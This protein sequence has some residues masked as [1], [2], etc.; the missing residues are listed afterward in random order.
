[1]KLKQILFASPLFPLYGRIVRV[2]KPKSL[3][4]LALNTPQPLSTKYGLDRGTPVNRYWIRKA[5]AT[6][7]SDITGT[8]LE[9]GDRRY[10]T[11]FGKQSVK[12]SDILD[13]VPTNSTATIIGDLRN[14]KEQIKNNTYDC[15]ILTHVLGM[16]D[17]YPA[18]IRE[19]HRIL[20]PGGVMLVTVSSFSPVLEEAASYWRFTVAGAKY[21]FSQVFSK[22]TVQSYGNVYSGQAFWVGMAQEELSVSELDYDDPR[23]PCVIAIR[24]VKE[25]KV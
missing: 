3:F 24:A 8:V 13:I 6:W 20:K 2:V 17:D 1:M 11:E 4:P 21:A 16:I 12:K 9:I 18:A 14:V 15:I 22:I 7:K 23:Y 25:D 19:C 10:T 5:I